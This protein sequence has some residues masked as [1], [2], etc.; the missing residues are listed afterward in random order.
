MEEALC[1]GWIDSKPNVLDDERYMQL[2]S[3][4]KEKSPW[5]KL[6]KQRVEKLIEQGVMTAAGLK[7]IEA[8]QQHGSWNAY[9]AIEDLKIP[10]DL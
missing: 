8:T 5:S 2:F 6:N 10:E 1:F 9:D 7:V 4:R 3:P